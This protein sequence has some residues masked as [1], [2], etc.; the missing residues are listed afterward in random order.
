MSNNY[1]IYIVQRLHSV[2]YC[3]M[4]QVDF[5]VEFWL[6]I[7]LL[8]CLFNQYTSEYNIRV[9]KLLRKRGHNFVLPSVKQKFNR[10]PFIARS[11]YAYRKIC[12][13][14]LYISFKV[15]LF[16]FYFIFILFFLYTGYTCIMFM[17]VYIQINPCVCKGDSVGYCS[18]VF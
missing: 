18:F 2:R 4:L 12:G 13:I 5:S 14:Y 6:L 10:Q 9:R 8:F 1:Q 3:H 16:Y 17:H 7:C 15:I 11:L